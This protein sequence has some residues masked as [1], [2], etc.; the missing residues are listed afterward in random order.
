MCYQTSPLY[1]RFFSL[2]FSQSLDNTSITSTN[3]KLRESGTILLSVMS[4][5]CGTVPGIHRC[6][7]EPVTCCTVLRPPDCRNTGQGAYPAQ[8]QALS[9]LAAFAHLNKR[10]RLWLLL[11]LCPTLWLSFHCG[12]GPLP[13]FEDIHLWFMK[14]CGNLWD[15]K[16]F[17]SANDCQYEY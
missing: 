11:S 6:H 13:S 16:Q 8:R 12:R 15:A 4:P 5:A 1:L 3:W 9:S 2:P 7:M 10:A 17:R 14:Y